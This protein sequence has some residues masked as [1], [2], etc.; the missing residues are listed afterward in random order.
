MMR[1]LSEENAEVFRDNLSNLYD[2]PAVYD[3]LVLNLLQQCT[4][5]SEYDTILTSDDIQ[6]SASKL[7]NAPGDSG[8]LPWKD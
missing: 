4:V 2:R 1:K 3:E 5:F 8:I 6:R 7:K